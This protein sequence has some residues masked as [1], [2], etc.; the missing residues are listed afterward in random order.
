MAIVREYETLY[1]IAPEIEEADQQGVMEALAAVVT[2]NGGEI[3]KN[4]VWGKR[5]LAYTIKKRT[6]GIYVLLRYKSES[7]VPGELE[8][9]VHRT[10]NILRHLTTVVSHQQLKEEARLKAAENKRVEDA[11][12]RE[13]EEAK[14]AEEA[15]AA[16]A[17]AAAEA[18]AAP[19]PAEETAQSGGSES[20]VV[21]EE[22][23]QSAPAE[24]TAS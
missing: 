12:R 15:A 20:P 19:A 8:V 13:A 10:P 21:A 5:K 16:E 18:E 23:D 7:S 1:I 2:K 3:V 24:E 9:F 22:T 17:K 4:D 6:E 14:R 11:A